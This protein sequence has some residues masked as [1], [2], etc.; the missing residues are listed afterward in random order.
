MVVEKDFKFLKNFS[1][2]DIDEELEDSLYQ[3]ENKVKFTKKKKD[4]SP[5]KNGKKKKS[6]RIIEENLDF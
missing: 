2:K 6:N 1:L 3:V 5:E 4:Y